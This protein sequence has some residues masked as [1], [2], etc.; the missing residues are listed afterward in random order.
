VL[1]D[2]D[3]I[4][5]SFADPADARSYLLQLAKLW[6]MW[7][8]GLAVL[9]STSGWMLIVFGVLL[10]VA[11]PVLAKPLVTRAEAMFPDHETVD[12][13][14]GAMGTGRGTNRDVAVRQLVYGAAPVRAALSAIGAS[15]AWVGLLYLGIGVTIVAFGYVLIDVFL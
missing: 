2:S 11:L 10:L 3:E 5:W 14:A 8:I 13:G 4:Q 1:N 12:T 6:A 9:F 7:L 15:Q